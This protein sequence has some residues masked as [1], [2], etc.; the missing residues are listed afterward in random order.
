MSDFG[1]IMKTLL[2]ELNNT[3]ITIQDHVIVKV[4]NSLDLKFET[5]VTILNKKARNKKVLLDLNTLLKNLEEEEICMA[6]KS[7][8]N[9]VQTSFF[10]ESSRGGQNSHGHDGQGSYGGQRR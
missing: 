8:L 7:L 1:L 3:A 5:Y 9:N 6:E 2:E 10:G 4:I